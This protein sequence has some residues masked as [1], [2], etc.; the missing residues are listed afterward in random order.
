[1][2]TGIV[3][4]FPAPLSCPL[5][6]FGMD[7]ENMVSQFHIA[8]IYITATLTLVTIL[9]TQL[10]EFFIILFPM[11]IYEP[12]E[13]WSKTFQFTTVIFLNILPKYYLSLN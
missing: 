13:L 7:F 3:I 4:L 9:R 5:A 1:V 2:N 11:L 12:K 8:F 10:L 6:Q